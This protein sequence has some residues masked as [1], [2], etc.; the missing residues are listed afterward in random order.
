MRR[1][2]EEYEKQAKRLLARNGKEKSHSEIVEEIK[3]HKQQFQSA[4]YE[5]KDYE[6]AKMHLESILTLYKPLRFY[7]EESQKRNQQRINEYA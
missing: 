2:I 7:D 1:Q 4:Y 6:K 5:K 3:M